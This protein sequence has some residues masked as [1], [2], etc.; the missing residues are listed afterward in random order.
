MKKDDLSQ[1]F[2]RQWVGVGREDDLFVG[3]CNL[4][5]CIFPVERHDVCCVFYHRDGLHI[6]LFSD[7]CFFSLLSSV[8]LYFGWQLKIIFY[9]FCYKEKRW[10][11]GA[12]IRKWSTKETFILRNYFKRYKTLEVLFGNVTDKY[13]IY[14]I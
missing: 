3:R 7:D 1:A 5:L 13:F 2:Q 10:L 8:F 9:F 6:L 4:C 12:F 11:L 14:I